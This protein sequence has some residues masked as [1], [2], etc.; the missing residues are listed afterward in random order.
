MR[1]RLL[2]LV[3]L[4]EALQLE[5]ADRSA[6]VNIVVLQ[7]DDREFG[8]LVDGITDTEEIVVKPLGRHLKDIAVFAGATIMGNG[9]IALILDVLGL[10]HEAGV[11]A[12]LGGHAA[13]AQEEAD[14]VASRDESISSLVVRVGDSGRLALPL[15]S[16]DRL[17]EFRLG[18]VEYSADQEVM[19]YRGGIL[20]LVRMS[21]ALGYSIRPDSPVMEDE[22]MLQVVV[23]DDGSQ[24]VGLVVE[25]VLDIV[26]EPID[27]KCHS[28]REGVLGSAVIRDR[29]TDIVD[30]QAVMERHSPRANAA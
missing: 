2:P 30:I 25:E 16:V 22:Q 17:E 21:E 12:E 1:G 19:Q 28:Q 10:A 11:V 20:P 3:D 24:A 29:V 8:L 6:A 9:R 7:A 4:R 23:Y 18:S 26:D 15:A 5:G 14:E 13:H 27:L